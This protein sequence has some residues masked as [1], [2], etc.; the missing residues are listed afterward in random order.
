MHLK[1]ELELIDVYSLI[2]GSIIGAGLFLL[3]GLAHAKA[4]NAFILSYILAG[5]LVSTSML[6]MAE[7]ISAMPKAGGDY[8]VVK[9]VLGPAIGTISGI[10]SW[11][12]LAQKS[13]LALYGMS[14]FTD[15]ILPMNIHVISIVLAVIFIVLNILGV[16]EAGRI[17]VFLT[18]LLLAS[19]L[20]YIF[21]GFW[22]IDLERYGN[23]AP[24]G[25]L[26]VFSTA[27]FIFVTYGGILKC[28]AV[29]EEIKNPGRTIPL[30][31]I[32]S[33][34]TVTFVYVFAVIIT[35]GVLDADV[36]HKSAT[37]LND[38]AKRFMGAPGIIL[39]AFA[40]ILACV[41]TANG[42]IMAASRYPLALSHD[43]LLPNFLSS[44]NKR[45]KTPHVA[46]IFTGGFVIL[47]LFLNL[48]FLAKAS[49]TFLILTYV[50]A[51]SC[52]LIIR[53]SRIQNYQ[54]TFR[55][56]LYPWLQIA[57]IIGYIFILYQMGMESLLITFVL[58]TLGF[59]VYWFYGRARAEKEYA[60][61]HLVER[62]INKDLPLTGQLETE[63]KQI[64]R[65]REGLVKDRFDDL[66][67]K[68]NVLDIDMDM[69]MEEFYK[70][71]T[72]VLSSDINLPAEN[73]LEKLVEREIDTTTVISPTIAV[74]HIIIEGEHVF[75][76]ILVRSKK[77]IFF[78][79]SASHIHTVFVLIG[80]RDERNFHLRALSSIAQIIHD[81]HFEKKWMSAKN[82]QALRDIILLGAR[83]R[84]I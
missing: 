6:S 32:L 69:S 70:K 21:R 44:I 73:I 54:P 12:F 39:M 26:P 33:L 41:T 57:G 55:S 15:M 53:E 29:A 56:P 17:Q 9:R 42:G 83:K 84:Y 64:I 10:L 71:V 81:P 45:F 5:L 11:F 8:F 22:G 28:V 1:K 46:I 31:M 40:A 52:L 66:V 47:S 23:F 79:E 49:S 75:D 34:L 59:M 76:I 20:A 3:P 19:L 35:T 74:P 62:I 60:L 65:E 82:D 36:F 13:A 51:N 58:V 7:L 43:G 48:E 2:T 4:G 30:A 18:L 78:S 63:L 50:V 27:G 37:P 67:E 72:D 25:F 16:K 68:C 61:L 77:G 38:A 24:Y 14:I 80:S